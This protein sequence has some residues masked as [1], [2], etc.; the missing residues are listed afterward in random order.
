M[1]STA[2]LLK[3]VL[4]IAHAPNCLLCVRSL[5]NLSSVQVL[6][7]A[8]EGLSLCSASS[9]SGV[10]GGRESHGAQNGTVI[11]LLFILLRQLPVKG[12]SLCCKL[13]QVLSAASPSN[14]DNHICAIKCRHFFIYVSFAKLLIRI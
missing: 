1:M 6:A 3:V 8:A 5:G 4:N 10:G 13:S 7:G 11:L 2:M 12:Y 9:Q 14:T